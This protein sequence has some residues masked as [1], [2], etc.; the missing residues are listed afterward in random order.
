M[1][2]ILAI[3]A[4]LMKKGFFFLNEPVNLDTMSAKLV[5]IN[6]QM[7]AIVNTAEAEERDISDEELDQLEALRADFKNT[8]K[9]IDAIEGLQ[10]QTQRLAEGMGRQTAP[11][12]PTG[13]P[14]AA[15]APVAVAPRIEVMPHATQGNHGFR[16]LGEFAIVARA[17][18]RPQG[19]VDPRIIR[20]QPTEYG[21]EGVGAEGGVA[22]PPDFRT[23]IWEKVFEE[24]SLLGRTDQLPTSGNTL[25]L[26]KDETTPWQTAGGVQAYWE[27]EAAKIRESKPLLESVSY[28]TNK[29]TA[30][31]PV[32]E[33][34]LED[35]PAMDAYLRRKVPTKFSYKI[36]D[37]IVEG[38][39]A[40][41]ML[42]ILNSSA[43]I[44]VPKES[45]QT[46]G[47]IVYMNIVNM[48][49]RMYAPSVPN[50]VW[51]HNQDILPQLMT[52]EFPSGQNGTWP[53]W[54]PPGMLADAPHGTLMGR[55][56]VP[57]QGCPGLGEKGDLIF[58]DMK[59]Y[60]SVVKSIG[61]RTDVSMHLYF[62][63]DMSTYRFIM[64]L[65]GAPWWGE[66]ITPAKSTQTL[67]C[68]ITLDTRA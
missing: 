46:A 33:E 59:Q 3:L 11:S 64:R 24:D 67:S 4:K 34:L 17:S 58:A 39:G 32:T 15:P 1:N 48:F 14:P 5:E 44:S 45:G 57:I 41:E 35:A 36:Q 37:S 51:L 26:P 21:S 6:N 27:K 61:L 62:D 60:L 9:R 10:A 7:N 56:I 16:S 19:A 28:K 65:T 55:P 38:T 50:A 29:L 47:T 25:T 23:E 30:L 20:N 18:Q 52:M 53:A 68:F 2:T 42:G 12:A 40:G 22:V 31:V 54:M 8:Q 49:A 63:Y 13:D 66:P 43:T